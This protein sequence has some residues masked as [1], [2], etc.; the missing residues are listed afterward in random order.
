MAGFLHMR[1]HYMFAECMIISVRFPAIAA[2][3][4]KIIHV[5]RCPQ[6][7]LTTILLKFKFKSK[8]TANG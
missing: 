5:N 2:R 7:R 3:K 4:K 6:P 1:R 8:Q